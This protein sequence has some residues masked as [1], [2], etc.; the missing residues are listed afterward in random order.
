M[1]LELKTLDELIKL[2]QGKFF[3]EFNG[4]IDP[5][6]KS[7][8]ARAST[9]SSAAAALSDQE[10]IQEAE[11]QAFIQTAD[12]EFL[13]Y[14]CGLNNVV[15][16]D[17]TASNGF[18]AAPGTV[19]TAVPIDTP[20]T[21]SGRSYK[22]LSDAQVQNYTGSISLSW[23]G[24]VVTAETDGTHSLSTGLNVVISGATQSAYNG[25]F[26]ITAISRTKFTYEVSD[27]LTTDNASYSSD[28]ALLSIES[29]G[30]GSEQNAGSGS[31]FAI[32][33]TGLT[34]EAYAGPDGIDGG[35]DQETEDDFRAR[36]LESYNATPGIATPP[37]IKFSAKSIAGNTRVFVVR[38]DGTSGGTPG[39]AGYKPLAGETVVYVLRDND[40]SIIPTTEKLQETKDKIISDGNWPTFISDDALYLLAPNIDGVDFQF[41]DTVPNTDTM[42]ASIQ[43][44]I[45]SFF[46][47]AADF[48][49]GILL[50][51]IVDFLRTISDTTTGELL[52]E[53]RVTVTD[54]A[55]STTYLVIFETNNVSYDTATINPGEGGILTDGGITFG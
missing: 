32:T 2:I 36:G 40:A 25:T 26:T 35:L 17:P 51:D 50:T 10:G 39:Q 19:G 38:P 48:E 20:L 15:R 13:E 5:T 54:P 6:I 41:T 4:E 31:I 9:N 37:A 7:S 12:G 28:Y 45:P 47:D 8:F 1:P 18:T 43:S 24:G 14:H 52:T 29:N 16:F 55:T 3:S 49:T 23:S 30:T 42:R 46:E 33:V 11:R 27:T 34:G 53:F 22:V 44:S 21:F